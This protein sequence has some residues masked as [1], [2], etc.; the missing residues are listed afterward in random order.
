[1]GRQWRQVLMS[2]DP[3]QPVRATDCGPP[4]Q[5]SLGRS[6]LSS[7]PAPRAG[8]VRHCPHPDTN[9]TSAPRHHR[10]C[11]NAAACHTPT[12]LPSHSGPSA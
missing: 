3:S 5:L 4:S 6:M 1:M 11:M 9:G 7:T 2:P 10:P 8:A 12:R